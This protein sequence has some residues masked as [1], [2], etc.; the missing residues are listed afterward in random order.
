MDKIYFQK[1]ICQQDYSI[2]QVIHSLIKNDN[3]ILF[4]INTSG[5]LIGSI[6]YEDIKHYL[7]AGGKLDDLSLYA[8]NRQPE[9]AKSVDEA[10]LL[11]NKKVHNIIPI[12]DEE[13]VLT[14]FYDGNKNPK[15]I[16][17]LGGGGHCS[18]VLDSILSLRIYDEIGIIDFGK[19]SVLGIPVIGTED[20]LPQLFFGGW[21]DAFITVGSIGNTDIRHK[22]FNTIKSIGFHIPTVVDSS[23]IIA[24]NVKISEGCF[25]GKNAVV[26]AGSII[27]CCAILNTCSIIEHD[28]IVGDFCHISPGVTICGNVSVGN[29]THIGA[30]SVIKQQIKIGCNSIIGAGSVVVKNIPDGVT[31][32]GN[33]CEVVKK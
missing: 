27:G 8:A 15:R 23:A 10:S 29:N 28:C 25:V 22:L 31:A 30:G 20:N 32:Y 2:K 24:K 3:S 9:V 6:S 21:T 12:V 13:G 14:D 26:N 1:L 7:I 19:F 5:K 33:P 18:S 17:L 11:H 4:L 16:L